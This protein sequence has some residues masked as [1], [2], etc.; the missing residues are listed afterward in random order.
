MRTIQLFDALFDARAD[1][2]LPACKSPTVQP[3][4]RNASAE[5]GF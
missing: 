4:S 3:L 1:Y 2:G 5:S